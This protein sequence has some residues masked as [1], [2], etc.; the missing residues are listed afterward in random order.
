MTSA[1]FMT[2]TSCKQMLLHLDKQRGPP[3][4]KHSVVVTNTPSSILTETKQHK[5]LRNDQ[6]N[7]NFIG[8]L[9]SSLFLAL[10]QT[11]LG[12]WRRL[13]LRE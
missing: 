2:E 4:Y 6:G 11:Q 9:T 12:T 3:I 7:V 13:E 1:Y 8:P 10:R 5:I